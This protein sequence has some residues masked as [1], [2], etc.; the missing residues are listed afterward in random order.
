[1]RDAGDT[2]AV[3]LE[4]GPVAKD[5]PVRV[6][7]AFEGRKRF[8]MEVKAGEVGFLVTSSERGATVFNRQ[9]RE[10]TRS[11]QP[12]DVPLPGL[13]MAR[14]PATGKYNQ[15]GFW[16]DDDAVPSVP[17]L[18]VPDVAAEH[19]VEGLLRQEFHLRR[20]ER[21]GEGITYRLESAGVEPE[22]L[23]VVELKV[24]AE[25]KLRDLSIDHCDE[26]GERSKWSLKDVHFGGPLPD[27][28]FTVKLPR[29]TK[30][31]RVEKLSGLTLWVQWMTMFDR[32]GEE[33]GS[34]GRAML[35]AARGALGH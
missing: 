19:V 2:F 8:L 24:D 29:D 14:D 35:G 23:L 18:N 31:R 10:A 11:T 33:V 34:A 16:C 15:M 20:R 22:S 30:V 17:A 12:L 3:T 9:E 26:K 4:G 7:L 28:L 25:R 5:E 6:R 21:A 27:D 1:M 13:R 32:L